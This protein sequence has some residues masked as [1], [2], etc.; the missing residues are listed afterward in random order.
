MN[1]GRGACVA[2]VTVAVADFGYRVVSDVVV[3][4]ALALEALSS[5]P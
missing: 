5:R 4:A 1:F 2:D 3:E